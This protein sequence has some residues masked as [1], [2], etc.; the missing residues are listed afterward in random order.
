M[1]KLIMKFMMTEEREGIPGSVSEKSWCWETDYVPKL[2]SRR[3]GGGELREFPLGASNISLDR[4]ERPLR[5]RDGDSIL[6]GC[7]RVSHIRRTLAST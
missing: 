3:F 2:L 1:M 5:G 4:E 7:L 6:R